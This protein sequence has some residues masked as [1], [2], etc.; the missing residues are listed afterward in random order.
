MVLLSAHK[1]AA[2]KR[3]TALAQRVNAA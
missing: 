3:L 2:D 1:N